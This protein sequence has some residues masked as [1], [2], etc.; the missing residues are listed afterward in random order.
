MK[1]GR[2]KIEKMILQIDAI[3]KNSRKLEKQYASAL[4]KVHPSFTGRH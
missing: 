3:C 4:A 2:K 1:F